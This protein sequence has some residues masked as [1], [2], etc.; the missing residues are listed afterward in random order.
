MISM[1]TT[2]LKA[3]R[4]YPDCSAM[5]KKLHMMT[6]NA[7]EQVRTQKSQAAFLVQIA[8]RTP[9]K[10]LHCLSMRLTAEY[11]ALK[12][13]ERELP[14]QQKFHD[15]DLY[16]YAFSDNVL[17]CAVVVDSTISSALI[18]SIDK[19]DWLSTE[20]NATMQNQNSDARYA[21]SMNHLR[22]YL[23]YVFPLLNKIVFLDHDVVVQKDLTE[24]WSVYMKGKVNGAV[25]TCRKDDPSYR[26]MNIFINFSDPMVAKRFNAKACTWAFG[27]NVFNLQEWRRRNLTG[28]YY[29]YLQF[30]WKNNA[31]VESRQLAHRMGRLLQLDRGFGMEMARPW[32]RLSLWS[33]SRQHRAGSR[34]SSDNSPGASQDACNAWDI[35]WF[36]FSGGNK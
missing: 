20:F 23:P 10:T 19:F 16:C 30:V 2:L 13:E 27:M 31:I 32:F 24:L 14:N 15:P 26:Q 25:E 9:P 17:V 8:G 6:S 33:Q 29:Q 28:I 3:C 18:Q 36:R 34:D 35:Y 5:D 12:P 4:V 21:S 7:A 11:F 1:K 22:F